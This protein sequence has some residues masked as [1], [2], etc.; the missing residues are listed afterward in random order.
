MI[1]LRFCTYWTGLARWHSPTFSFEHFLA[2]FV[3]SP[4][5]D[6]QLPCPPSLLVPWE[7]LSLFL[8][9]TYASRCQS[10]A[11]LCRRDEGKLASTVLQAPQ[12]CL[13]DRYVPCLSTSSPWVHRGEQTTLLPWS[14]RKSLDL[15]GRELAALQRCP[16]CSESSSGVLFLTQDLPAASRDLGW[17]GP[18]ARPASE[19]PSFYAPFRLSSVPISFF[20]SMHLARRPQVPSPFW[21][22]YA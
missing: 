2:P 5:Q 6:P 11:P 12:S 3:G 10:P 15:L 21:V 18:C 9:V 20:R 17:W 13:W 22:S 1:Y 14:F 4:S 8:L 19:L 16:R 7:F